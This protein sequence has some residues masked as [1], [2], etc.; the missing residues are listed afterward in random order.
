MPQISVFTP[1]MGNKEQKFCTPWTQDVY[2]MSYA[3]FT[4][5]IHR[6][7]RNFYEVRGHK[8]NLKFENLR[9]L[10]E[11]SDL[12]PTAPR[13]VNDAQ[14]ISHRTLMMR[15]LNLYHDAV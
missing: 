6:V 15:C 7:F 1:N 2:R 12:E 5:C 14:K 4:S 8:R 11:V 9:D 3:K 13:K 10:P